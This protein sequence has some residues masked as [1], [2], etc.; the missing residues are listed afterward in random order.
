MPTA[1]E[2]WQVAAQ[3]ASERGA[4]VVGFTEDS[5][6]PE[7]GST[8]DNVLGFAPRRAP[9]V[10]STSD[11]ADW[12]EQV[13]AFYRLRPS[14]GKGK[15]GDANAKYY[16]IKLHDLD[17][18][19]L[20]SAQ[21]VLA[22]SPLPSIASVPSFSGYAEATGS[23]PGVK[24]WPRAFAR[25]IDFVVHRVVLI[26]TGFM[27]AFML[28]IA[29]GGRPPVW[30]LRRLTQRGFPLFFAGIFGLIAYNVI[31]TA[32][33]GSTLGKRL[34]SFQVVQ[35]DGSP[36]S[37]KSAIIRELGYF[38]DVLFFGIVGYTAMQGD[39]QQKRHGDDWAHTVVC[40]RANVPEQ[41][42]QIGM[43]FV[44]GLMLGI[45]ADIA[46]LMVGVLVQM[47]S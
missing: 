15:S 10:I 5:R 42:R 39:P 18:M 13:E 28:T 25:L 23:L 43:K 29:A 26:I 8:L 27:F 37:I 33:S 32:V 6:L 30:V 31:C 19:S 11:W 40:K 17:G 12:N 14:W 34:C 35:D 45:F 44:L 20:M 7:L 9:T 41:S 38:I 2:F 4:L 47:N 22:G 24:F 16:R 1:D 21:A 36:C 3:V 46:F